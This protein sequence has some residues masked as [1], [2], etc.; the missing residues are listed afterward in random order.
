VVTGVGGTELVQS[1][2]GYTS[3]AWNDTDNVAVDKNWSGTDDPIPH[4]TGGGK[5]ARFGRP[6]YQNGSSRSPV[7]AAA[8]P[9]SR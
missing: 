8:C 3:V 6:S 9:T 2:G 5:S 1:G 7:P 4:A